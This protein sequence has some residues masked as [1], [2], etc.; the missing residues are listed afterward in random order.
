MFLNEPVASSYQHLSPPTPGSSLA[1]SINR[2]FASVAV[3][4]QPLRPDLCS[5]L[6]D[7]DY[8]SQYVIEPWQVA[9][10]LHCLNI[11]KASGPDLVPNWFLEEFVSSLAEPACAIFNQSLMQ[12]TVHL[13]SCGSQ[14]K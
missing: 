14:L 2:F 4:L 12:R 8:G 11:H 9:L 10:A 5:D 13:R 1:D 6:S 3:D 7:D